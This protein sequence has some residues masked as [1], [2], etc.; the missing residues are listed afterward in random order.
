M[1]DVQNDQ[2]SNSY[3]KIIKGMELLRKNNI[4]F[5]INTVC[6]EELL[7]HDTADVFNEIKKNNINNFEF[8]QMSKKDR[9]NEKYNQM[10][11]KFMIGMTNEYLKN[12]DKT[13]DFRFVNSAIKEMVGKKG[14]LCTHSGKNCGVHPTIDAYGNFHFC[15]N[16]DE[17][18]YLV[19][20]V[21]SLKKISL[22]EA[23]QIESYQNIR[24]NPRLYSDDCATCDVSDLCQGG[25]PGNFDHKLQQNIFCSA[26][27]QIFRHI[28]NTV[29]ET[30]N[31]LKING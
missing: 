25:C 7:Q 10:Y 22:I 27:K 6:S 29:G 28:K 15:D 4:N 2:R 9:D 5:S 24:E 13:M 17:K 14:S 21:A 8:S 3:K 12:D 19:K 23:V 11:A 30:V 16:Y 31:Y 20:D 26:Y 1:E 18:E